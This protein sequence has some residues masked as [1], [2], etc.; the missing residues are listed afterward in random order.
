MSMILERPQTVL[1]F[2]RAVP[3]NEITMEQLWRISVENYHEMIRAGIL[4]SSDPIE[5]LEGWLILKMPKKP[6]HVIASELFRDAL[7]RVLTP[8]FH[9]NSQQPMTL[10]DSEPE[11]DVSVVRGTRRDYIEQNPGPKDVPLVVEVSDTSIARDQTLKKRVYARA[12]IAEYWI[13]N[14]QAERIE[15]YSTP[16]GPSDSPDYQNAQSYTRGQFVA[17]R[18][19]GLELGQIAV[20]DVL[21]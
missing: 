10:A 8:S 6:P 14:L 21:P 19:D 11:P 13:V 16:S 3:S 2:S 17:L 9:I 4:Q 18:L 15:V 1:E 7:G 20:N 12:G 5:L